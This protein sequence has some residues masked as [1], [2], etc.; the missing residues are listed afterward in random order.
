MPAGPNSA[1]GRPRLLGR[2]GE[3]AGGDQRVARAGRSRPRPTA[4]WRRSA[5]RRGRRTARPGAPP[6]RPACGRG[7]S[8]SSRAPPPRSGM[9]LL[10]MPPA[11]RVTDAT[12]V[13]RRPSKSCGSGSCAASAAMPAAARWIALSASHGRAEWPATP[14]KRPGRVDVAEAAGVERVVGR[15]HHHHELGGETGS[16]VEQR[17]QRALGERQ[18]LAAEE[19]RRRAARRRAARARSSPPARPSC[20]S[21]RGRGRARRR[22]GRAG[23]PGPGRCRGGR[24]AARGAPVRAGRARRCR[25]GRAPAAAAEPRDVRRRAAPRRATPRGCRSARASARR[26]A[27]RGRCRWRP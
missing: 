3:V 2:D 9:T 23:C 1:T 16:R 20:R 25:R 13:K 10:A 21:R 17:G 8:G 4:R 5:A 19:Q 14:W 18:L 26:G 27:R 12:S 6:P 22:G 24:R 7:R 15:L 11:I